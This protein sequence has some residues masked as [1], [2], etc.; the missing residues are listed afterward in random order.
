MGPKKSWHQLSAEMAADV[1]EAWSGVVTATGAS[2]H[3]WTQKRQWVA[4]IIV[5]LKKRQWVANIIVILKKKSWH[6]LLAEMAADV[7]EAWSG[8][9]TATGASEH[10]WTQKKRWH[11]LLAEMAADVEEAWSGVVTAT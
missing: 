2:E 3:W 4:N 5:I 7:E 1:E 11:Q 8:V 10:W 6:Q 9:V